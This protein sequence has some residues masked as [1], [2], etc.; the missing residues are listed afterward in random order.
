MRAA[1]VFKV[2][3]IANFYGVPVDKVRRLIE[4]D[5]LAVVTPSPEV[6]IHE[7]D[8]EAF[9]ATHNAAI[10]EPV[11]RGLLARLRGREKTSLTS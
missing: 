11:R 8:L 5:Q 3:D 9:L 4:S 10:F 6:R 7:A 1:H 2:E